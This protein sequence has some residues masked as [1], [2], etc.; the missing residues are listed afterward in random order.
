MD[1]FSAAWRWITQPTPETLFGVMVGTA[2]YLACVI[3]KF[4]LKAIVKDLPRKIDDA[5][6]WAAILERLLKR[7]SQHFFL[8]IAIMSAVLIANAP[9]RVV[10]AARIFF[11]I[12]G[13]VQAAILI[14]EFALSLLQRQA[15]RG[16]EEDPSNFNSALTILQWLVNVTTWT[17]AI[18]VILSNLNFNVTGLVTGLGIGGIAIGLAAQDLFK[19]L[20]AALAILFDEPFRKGDFISD[21][22]RILGNVEQ[23]GMKSTRIRALSGEQ[24]VLTNSNL[25]ALTLQNYGR[26]YRRRVVVNIGLTYQTPSNKIKRAAEIQRE[27]VEKHNKATFDRAHFMAYGPSSLDYELVFFIETPD[28]ATF[29]DIQQDVLLDIFQSYRDEGLEFA[30]PTRTVMVSSAAPYETTSSKT[31]PS[32]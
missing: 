21:G 23:I 22:D 15:L 2:M 28:Y 9:E 29:M 8:A 19:D 27:A 4:V 31:S 26:L 14:R 24:V 6:S 11:I 17:I 3:L 1:T 30:Y 10:A 12:S 7:A 32:D 18:V 25:L 13:V 5:H 16:T 20:F